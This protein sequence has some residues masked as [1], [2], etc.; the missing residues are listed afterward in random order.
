ML[1][2]AIEPEIHELIE[3]KDFA[4]LKAVLGEM[5]IHDLADLLSD[6]A[7]E[8]AAVCFRLLSRRTA[9]EIFGSLPAERREVLL[10]TLSSHRLA[11][12]INSMPPDERTELLEELPGEVAQKL[13]NLLRGLERE[14]TQ[15]LMAYPEETIGRLMTP[16]YVAVRPDWTIERVLQHIRR[17]AH[18]KETLNVIYVVDDHWKLLDEVPLESMVLSALDDH[19]EDLLDGHVAMLSA[20]E[21][22]ETAL[23]IFRKYEAVAMP[24][25]N[26]EGVLVGIV[27]VDDVLDVADEE[28]A[29]DYS[30]LTAM[31]PLEYSYFGTGFW[32]MLKK[33][34]P[35]LVLLL[36]AQSLT[37]VALRGFGKVVDFAVL[38]AFV[39]LINSPAGN[40]GTQ[41]AGLVLRGLAVQEMALTDWLKVLLREAI[42]GVAMGVILGLLGGLIVLVLGTGLLHGV[43]VGLAILAAVVLANLIGSML[44][45]FFKWLGVDPAVTS[46]PFIA[47]VMDV[48]AIMIYFSIAA[49]IL[50]LSS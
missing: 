49:A 21:D 37:A 12:L 7:D 3:A 11:E 24:V 13:L 14:I 39:P 2:A 42:R 26:D 6:L 38:V 46:G 9:A 36:V 31:D 25:V 47:S 5:E 29:E 30:K 10:S 35:W 41:M 33:R 32:G 45:F 22:Q 40:T 48:T 18:D 17:V 23:E 19:V 15:K 50:S 16:E 4:T 44:P 28:A 8:E 20:N 43:S 1:S 27:T 34:L